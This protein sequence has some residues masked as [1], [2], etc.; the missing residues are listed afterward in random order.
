MKRLGIFFGLFCVFIA[1]AQSQTVRQVVAGTDTLSR[2]VALADSGDVI[3]LVTSG[4]IYRETARVAVSKNLT[5]R[6]A[7]G[8]AQKPVLR[9]FVND[10]IRVQASLFLK[11]IRLEGNGIAQYAMQLRDMPAAAPPV[12]LICEDVDFK[13]FLPAGEGYGLRVRSNIS[14]LREL[15][16]TNCTFDSIGKSALRLEFPSNGVDSIIFDECTFANISINGLNDGERCLR[17][18]FGS[19]LTP[20]KVR[21]NRCTFYNINEDAVRTSTLC[22]LRVLNSIFNRVRLNPVQCDTTVSTST[23]AF[24]DTIQNNSPFDLNSGFNIGTIYAEDPEFSNPLAF[25]FTISAF[26]AENFRGNDNRPLGPTR[27]HPRAS[28]VQ[29]PRSEKAVRFA[30]HQNYPNPFNPATNINY[31]L[32]SP[33]RV[34]LEVFDLLGRTVATLVNERQNQGSYTVKVN[35]SKYNLSSGVYF[36]RLQTEDFTSTRKMT[37]LK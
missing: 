9:W 32:S 2:V 1:T 37:L 20:P 16:F 24:C 15:R 17:I 28:S 21:V 4:G 5:I 22:E 7:Q 27:W 6:A 3:E 10:E 25:N 8:L 31:E 34:Q 18:E 12:S 35:A 30:L 26:F 29:N 13:T 36:Y 14:R 19:Y 11:G 33:S 23:V